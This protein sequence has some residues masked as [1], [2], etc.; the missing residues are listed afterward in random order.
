MMRPVHPRAGEV[1]RGA[2][3]EMERRMAKSRSFT[4]LPLFGLWLV[5]CSGTG[6]YTI[7]VPPN[8]AAAPVRDL[9]VG[10]D[11][12]RLA[13]AKA[14][15]AQPEHTGE[16]WE[17]GVW[18]V[19]EGKL[20]FGRA[21]GEVASAGFSPDGK[22]LAFV[23]QDGLWFIDMSGRNLLGALGS[24]GTVSPF[25]HMGQLRRVRF[26]AVGPS[27]LACGSD[28]VV[29][30]RASDNL[31]RVWLGKPECTALDVSPDGQAVALVFG[32]RDE[33][34][35]A[36]VRYGETGALIS[37]LRGHQDTVIDICFTGRTQVATASRDN[38]IRVWQAK[39]GQSLRVISI[40]PMV[41]RLACSPVGPVLASAHSND[42]TIHLWD[43]A[44]GEPLGVLHGQGGT[45]TALA[46]SPDGSALYS[47]AEDGSIFM[48][49][50]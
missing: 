3:A 37:Q 22:M 46:I 28:G 5:A 50:L 36:E 45:V 6:S 43:A 21:P 16:A 26:M 10:R 34:N 19:D 38:T 31:Q 41:T 12:K 44:S 15:G 14:L 24:D 17:L 18:S 47:G 27:A 13:M 39:T 42:P 35:L 40:P 23:A 11:S 33:H 32:L 7:L 25:L 4:W 20:E 1:S 49:S 29:A 30:H 48:W 9:A 8:Q 2:A